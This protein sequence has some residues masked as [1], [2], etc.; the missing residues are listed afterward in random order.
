MSGDA[1]ILLVCDTLPENPWSRDRLPAIRLALNG[2]KHCIRDVYEF[3]SVEH[4]HHLHRTKAAGFF[5]DEDLPELNQRF[6]DGVLASGCRI[7]VLGTVDNYVQFLLP[8]TIMRIRAAGIFT[9]GILGDDEFTWERNRLWIFLFDRVV[10]YVKRLVDYYN[11]LRPG[12]CYYF[13]NSCYFAERDY[14]HAEL[15]NHS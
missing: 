3:R 12:C 13:P 14:R 8:N 10:A 4:A 2:R 1:E 11:V 5:R 9:V 15:Q 7:L 6:L